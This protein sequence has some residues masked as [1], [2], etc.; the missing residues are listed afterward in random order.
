M[1][2]TMFHHV[3]CVN[4]VSDAQQGQRL[5]DKEKATGKWDAIHK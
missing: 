3:L 1:Y 4:H 2:L 5:S